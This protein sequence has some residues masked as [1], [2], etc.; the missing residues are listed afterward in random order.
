MTAVVPQRAAGLVGRQLD[1]APQSGVAA[2]QPLV[3]ERLNGEQ[4]HFASVA[5]FRLWLDDEQRR[6]QDE[7][8]SRTWRAGQRMARS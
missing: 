8:A 1:R 4:L 3:F 2:P 7:I 6:K 5:D